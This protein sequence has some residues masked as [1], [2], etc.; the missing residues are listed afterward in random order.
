MKIF[1]SREAE[2]SE[3]HGGSACLFNTRVG[4]FCIEFL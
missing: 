3:R 1:F 2:G 4:K